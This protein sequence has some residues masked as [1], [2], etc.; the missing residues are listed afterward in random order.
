MS[1]RLSGPLKHACYQ[2]R[3]EDHLANKVIRVC[4]PGGLLERTTFEDFLALVRSGEITKIPHM[5]VAPNFRPAKFYGRYKTHP[6]GLIVP[7]WG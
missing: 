7:N 4:G 1:P 2:G 6:L 3:L 5:R